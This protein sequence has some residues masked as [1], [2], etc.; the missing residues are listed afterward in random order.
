MCPTRHPYTCA[1]GAKCSKVPWKS[2]QGDEIDCDGS[3]LIQNED[4][5]GQS[6]C[7]PTEGVVECNGDGTKYKCLRNPSFE[8]KM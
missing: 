1:L 8:G 3:M 5:S 2:T 7:C 4:M 6:I